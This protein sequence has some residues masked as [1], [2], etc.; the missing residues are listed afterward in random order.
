MIIHGDLGDVTVFEFR[1]WDGMALTDGCMGVVLAI[2]GG[3]T[4][5]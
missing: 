5:W 4:R 1:R 3:I 2:A